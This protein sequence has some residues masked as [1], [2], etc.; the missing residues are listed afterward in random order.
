LLGWQLLD[1]LLL[2]RLLLE[3]EGLLFAKGV[4]VL[5]LFRGGHSHAAVELRKGFEVLRKGSNHVVVGGSYEKCG[6]LRTEVLVAALLSQV[7]FVGSYLL[8]R[9]H[10]VGSVQRAVLNL[11]TGTG[12]TPHCVV[13][14]AAVI[15]VEAP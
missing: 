2:G 6:L 5:D 9:T 13:K 4:I 14:N 15:C 7:L 8:H 3:S 10:R 11:L 1:A 12:L